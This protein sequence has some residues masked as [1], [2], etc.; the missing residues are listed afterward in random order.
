[1]TRKTDWT[2]VFV[3]AVT[4]FDA[5]GRLDEP[6]FLR[7]M[8][9]LVADG[10]DGIIV[11]GSTGEWYTQTVEEKL[12]LFRIAAGRVG[13]RARLIAGTSAIATDEAMH[14]TREAKAIG[15]DG[16]MVLAPPYALPNE[17]ELLQHFQAVAAVGLPLM[18]YNNPGRTQVTIT[19]PLAERLAALPAVVAL[20]DSSKDL[21]ELARTLRAVGDRLAVFCGLEPYA[22]AMIGR[23][24]VGTVSMA[25]NVIGARAVAFQRHLAAGRHAEARAI[26][27]A[28]DR[29][30]EAF[31]IGGYGVYTVIKTCM[32]LVGRP[33]GFPRRPHLPI[34]DAGVARLGAILDEIG[35]KTGAA[36]RAAE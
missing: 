26:E 2:G 22:A 19:A 21:Y 30:Y 35:V 5:E 6:A 1:M 29:L 14:L 17:R 25:A 32:N 16:A 3:V 34:D 36:A 24:A 7:L 28:I 20:K 15:C 12:H 23:G 33:G 10:V 31:Y 8:D 9:L 27:A 11:A 4:P 18:V 13:G